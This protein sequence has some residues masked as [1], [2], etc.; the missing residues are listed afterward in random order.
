MYDCLCTHFVTNVLVHSKTGQCKM[1]TADWLLT[2]VF[3]VRKQ[4]TG[5]LLSRSD[6]MVKT[7]VCSSLSNIWSSPGKLSY[8]GLFI[9]INLFISVLDVSKTLDALKKSLK[10]IV[11]CNSWSIFHRQLTD[12]PPTFKD[13]CI[14]RVSTAILAKCWPIVVWYVSQQVSWYIG[15]YIV[16]HIGCVSVNILTDMSIKC[17]L[18]CRSLRYFD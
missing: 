4:S 10:H 18:I 5:L 14:D 16:Q 17:W 8:R 2:I 6:C 9:S 7:M 1:Q 3:R 15:R 11:L 13:H 12:I